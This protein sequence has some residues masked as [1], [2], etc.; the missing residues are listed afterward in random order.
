MNTDRRKNIACADSIRRLVGSAL[1]FI[2]IMFS[3]AEARADEPEVPNI[4]MLVSMVEVSHTDLTSLLSNPT[5][6][7]S[8]IFT[9]ANTLVKSGR[10]KVVDSAVLTTRNGQATEITTVNEVIYPTENEQPEL[11]SDPPLSTA[12][13]R[14][15]LREIDAP[16]LIFYYSTPTAWDTRNV[17]LTISATPVLSRNGKSVALA[18]IPEWVEH[19]GDCL[20]KANPGPFFRFDIKRPD[21]RSLRCNTTFTVPTGAFELVSVLTPMNQDPVPAPVTKVLLFVRCEVPGRALP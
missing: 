13:H 3:A 1:T 2:A 20:V 11:I 19:R 12:E 21:F 10:A 16:P 6:S 7:G 4:R 9:A 8:E 15:W 5:A 17:G 14:A 18:I